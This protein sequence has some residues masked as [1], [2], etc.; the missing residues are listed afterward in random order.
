MVTTVPIMLRRCRYGFIFEDGLLNWR[1]PKDRWQ[2][3]VLNVTNRMTGLLSYGNANHKKFVREFYLTDKSIWDYYKRAFRIE[4]RYSSRHIKRMFDIVHDADI[5]YDR[6]HDNAHGIK[7]KPLTGG[8][9]SM[10]KAAVYNHHREQELA[11]IT[12]TFRPNYDLSL[13]PVKLPEWIEE[14]RIKTAHDMINAG[15]ECSH[16]IGTYVESSDIFVREK[17]IC[18]QISSRTLE[19]GQCYD[20]HDSI[21]PASKSLEKRLRRDLAKLQ[22]L[23]PKGGEV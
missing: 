18:A 5:I 15:I 9:A 8:A 1:I 23:L 14:I 17:N 4:C 21:T 10:F 12:R 11:K 6:Y 13:P 16:C 22:Q 7:F 19:V 20:V 2:W 3:Y